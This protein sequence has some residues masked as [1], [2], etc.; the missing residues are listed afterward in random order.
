MRELSAGMP[1][2]HDKQDP[3]HEDSDSADDFAEAAT[4]KRV[5]HTSANPCYNA[6]I[7]SKSV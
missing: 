2:G 7:S 6:Y 4:S 5:D 3:D 1:K